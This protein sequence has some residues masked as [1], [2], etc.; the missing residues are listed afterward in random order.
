MYSM[1]NPSEIELKEL[2]ELY[3]EFFGDNNTKIVDE[4]IHQPKQDAMKNLPTT[5][6]DPTQP[7]TVSL[8]R[9]VQQTEKNQ[10]LLPQGRTNFYSKK[11]RTQG[12]K[13]LYKDGVNFT[14][15]NFLVGKAEK[16]SI[17]KVNLI[18]YLVQ[19]DVDRINNEIIE[20][21]IHNLL[22]I[23][24]VNLLKEYDFT[25]FN[26]DENKSRGSHINI[27]NLGK[28]QELINPEIK[29]TPAGISPHTIELSGKEPILKKQKTSVNE[30]E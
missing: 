6:T 27:Y 8:N 5:P 22:W 28:I 13:R 20:I 2:D 9:E 24:I 15:L 26:K 19:L 16:E 17:W 21:Q 11:A 10:P 14:T 25:K 23:R 29:N 12:L 7:F 30:D 4:A 3:E 1:E 18:D